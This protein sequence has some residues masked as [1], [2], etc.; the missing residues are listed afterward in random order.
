MDEIDP[1]GNPDPT[2]VQAA[3][4]IAARIT[5][6]QYPDRLPG[7]RQL[8]TELGIAY[9][10]LRRATALLRAR[11]LIITRQGRG[12]FPAPAPRHDTATWTS[13]PA[14]EG[15]QHMNHPSHPATRTT[16]TG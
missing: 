13:Q 11:G 9:Q 12:D 4:I 16:T 6:G 3:H 14:P 8:A 1:F 2:Y 5:A 10:T 15:H 7:E